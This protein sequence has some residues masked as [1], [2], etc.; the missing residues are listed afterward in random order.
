MS[1]ERGRE[2]GRGEEREMLHLYIRPY[3]MTRISDNNGNY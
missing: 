2:G 1:E 3:H